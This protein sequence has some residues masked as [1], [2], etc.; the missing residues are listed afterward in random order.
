MTQPTL[1]HPDSASVAVAWLSARLPVG[2]ATKLPKLATW[3]TYSGTIR[4]FVT[5]TV[6]GGR[7]FDTG[8][9]AP[10]VSVGTWASVPGSDSP[11]PGAAVQLAELIVSSCFEDDG[12]TPAQSVRKS[13]K[14]RAASVRSVRLNAEPREIADPDASMS[15]FETEIE[16]FWT[17]VPE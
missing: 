3:P 14:Y 7:T 15:H 11:Q 17:E 6:A 5:V 9:R 16:M 4:G 12:R 10:I 1:Y 8:L 13:A 2:V